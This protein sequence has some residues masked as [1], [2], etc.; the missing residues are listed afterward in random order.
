MRF[1]F[2]LVFLL[3]SLSTTLAALPTPSLTQNFIVDTDM[4][5]D[6]A[7]ALLYFLKRPEIKVKAILIESMDNSH[8]RPALM[9]TIRLLYLTHHMEVPIACGKG[10]TYYARHHS[11]PH[12]RQIW[13]T[14]AYTLLHHTRMLFTPL[15]AKDLL[16]KTLRTSSK[17]LDILALG[18]LSTLVSVL[19]KKP[20]LK[21]KIHTIYA[22]GGSVSATNQPN[23]QITGTEWNIYL[24]PQ[25][26]QKIFNTGIPLVLVPLDA[27]HP[28]P[29]D[30][31]F[32]VQIQQG[33]SHTAKFLFKLLKQRKSIANSQWYLD[34]LTAVIATDNIAACPVIPLTIRLA[35]ENKSSVTVIDN[36]QGIPTHICSQINMGKFKNTLIQ[37]LKS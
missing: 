27:T 31:D 12:L 6:D 34:P 23:I 24:D 37:T 30:K 32:Y 3:T 19:E 26:V 18:P 22:M 4:G 5:I 35:P 1:I 10:N 11:S 21:N 16:T 8:C 14:F 15:T 7:I 2:L 36:P 13:D 9:N 29:M 17:P 25:V 33:R 20:E 28:M